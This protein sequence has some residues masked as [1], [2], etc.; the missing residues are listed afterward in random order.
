LI[1][2]AHF[3]A[4]LVLNVVD[5]ADWVARFQA[6]FPIVQQLPSLPPANVLQA[7]PAQHVQFQ[8][9][10]N[11]PLPRMLLRSADGKL[12]IQLQGDRFGLGWHRTE[13]LGDVSDYPGFARIDL[14]FEE[15]L[16]RFDE[17]ASQRFHQRPKHRL[18]EL[19]Y[20]NA[21]LMER[22]GHRRRL[23]D[24][25]RFVQPGSRRLLGFQTNWVELVDAEPALPPKAT[26]TAQVGLATAPQGQSVL[27]FTFAGLGTVANGVKSKHILH[28]LHAKIR[29]IYENTIIP[30]AE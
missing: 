2:A 26:V 7:G 20:S 16:A 28:D 22:G 24:L 23:S 10:L 11:T 3:E 5:L 13:P 6:D 8:M 18:I 25:F 12:S 27:A 17:W 14:M 4:P 9:M 19:S 15:Q 29:E 30:D 1:V 21:S